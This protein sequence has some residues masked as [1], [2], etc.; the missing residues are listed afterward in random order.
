MTEGA[1]GETQYSFTQYAAGGLFRWV[2]HGFQTEKVYRSGWSKKHEQEELALGRHRWQDTMELFPTL[3]EV[4][5][6][7]S[8]TPSPL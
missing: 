6:L 2:E 3:E 7:N 8:G 1:Q 4:H 5:S